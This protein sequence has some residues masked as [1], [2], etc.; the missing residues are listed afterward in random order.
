MGSLGDVFRTVSEITTEIFGSTKDAD[1]AVLIFDDSTYSAL[2]AENLVNLEREFPVGF[3]GPFEYSAEEVDGTLILMSDLK[4]IIP[5][6]FLPRSL[7][8]KN[9]QIR[10]LGKTY[11]VMKDSPSVVNGLVID[12]TLQLRR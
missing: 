5:D 1:K 9:M 10:L 3:S 2:Q 6:S 11:Q 12:H 8:L 7:D 4:I